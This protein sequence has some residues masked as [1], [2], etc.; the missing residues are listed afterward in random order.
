[1]TAASTS[2]SRKRSNGSGS[3]VAIVVVGILAAVIGLAI[4]A[5]PVDAPASAGSAGAPAVTGTAADT[6]EAT[7][8]SIRAHS[9]QA[10][11]PHGRTYHTALLEKHPVRAQGRTYH[12]IL[13][14]THPRPSNVLSVWD[15]YRGK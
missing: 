11:R 2:I 10:V 3:L 1:M 7:V 12:T 15:P 6:S 8:Q 4:T 14:E 5:R 13:L 9:G